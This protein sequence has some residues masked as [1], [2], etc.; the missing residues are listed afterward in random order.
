[1]S[2][3]A[4]TFY[5]AVL[6]GEE[7]A[8]WQPWYG[9]PTTLAEACRQLDELLSNL[10]LKEAE[11]KASFQAIIRPVA[12]ILQ[13]QRLHSVVGAI[14]DASAD[15]DDASFYRKKMQELEQLCIRILGAAKRDDL[16]IRKVEQFEIWFLTHGIQIEGLAP[17]VSDARKT[18]FNAFREQPRIEYIPTGNLFPQ[19]AR[20]FLSHCRYFMAWGKG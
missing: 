1:M 15:P 6:D 9:E 16:L 10:G 14:V 20:R 2:Q 4:Q 5:F 18:I 7:P 8:A 3:P 19:E 12:S 11:P 17:W 13:S